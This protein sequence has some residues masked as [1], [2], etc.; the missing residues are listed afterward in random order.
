MKSALKAIVEKTAPKLLYEYQIR[1]TRNSEPEIN[2]LPTLCNRGKVSIDVGANRGLYSYHMLP[3]SSAVLA[4]EPLPLMQR[5]LRTH[6][7]KRIAIYPV[8]LSDHDGECEIRL[9]KGNHSWATI[10]PQNTLSLASDV[11]I[12]VI[13]VATRRLDSYGLGGV[14]FIKIDVEG[15]EEGVLRGAAETIARSKPTLLIE[16]E[17]RH[18]AGSIE[19]VAGFLK[20]L[21][22]RGYFFDAGILKPMEEFELSKDQPI[23]NVEVSG[24]VGRYINNFIFKPS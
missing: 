1:R 11:E 23:T 17:E 8:A 15:H 12:E 3:H 24:K 10:D 21:G 16:I 13:K 7:G 18:N 19:R 14:G 20:G 2:L 5:R 22:Y 6:L 4:F 9:P